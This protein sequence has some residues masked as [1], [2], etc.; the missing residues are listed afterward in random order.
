MLEERKKADEFHEQLSA[1]LDEVNEIRD[2]L[3]Q[4]RL[5]AEKWITDHNESVR[6]ARSTPDKDTDLAESLTDM[7]LSGGSVTLGGTRPDGA[8]SSS[9][10]GKKRRRRSAG[11]GRRAGN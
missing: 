4:Q 1:L 2:E 5:E 9:N 10:R 7:L 6:K 3:N 11:G 8:T